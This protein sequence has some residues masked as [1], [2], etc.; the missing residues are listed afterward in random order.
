MTR[1]LEASVA[2][3]AGELEEQASRRR[4]GEQESSRAGRTWRAGV[5]RRAEP[6]Q[7]K[8]CNIWTELQVQGSLH[9]E[10]QQ[11]ARRKWL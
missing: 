4:A 11:Q 1:L 2:M 9:G 5:A 3:V 7:Q 6:W 8:I 10:L